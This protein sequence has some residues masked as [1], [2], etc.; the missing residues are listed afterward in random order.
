MGAAAAP[1]ARAL[2]RVMGHPYGGGGG[3]YAAR[4]AQANQKC[5]DCQ[6]QY[7]LISSWALFFLILSRLVGFTSQERKPCN[8]VFEGSIVFSKGNLDPTAMMDLPCIIYNV[9]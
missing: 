5:Q 2:G 4:L 9:K 3:T 7:Q 6:R 8:I 1:V